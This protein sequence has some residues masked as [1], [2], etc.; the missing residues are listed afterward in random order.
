MKSKQDL[1]VEESINNVKKKVI[2]LLK[3]KI[4]LVEQKE[5][6]QVEQLN[7]NID[8]VFNEDIKKL[9]IFVKKIIETDVVLMQIYNYIKNVKSYRNNT[10]DTL[11]DV[12]QNNLRKGLSEIRNL[13]FDVGEIVKGLKRHTK[14]DL[15]KL[16]QDV[17]NDFIDILG[18]VIKRLLRL[19]EVIRN[20]FQIGNGL[21]EKGEKIS[22]YRNNIPT[23]FERT[24]DTNETILLFFDTLK[25]SI[26]VL[27]QYHEYFGGS[28][29]GININ[30]MAKYIDRPNRSD[31]EI[32]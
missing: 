29:L 15:S 31:N 9:N 25:I 28:D 6:E 20:F 22:N 18:E 7:T 32:D 8:S 26:Q 21:D 1:T 5:E 14:Y 2:E 11:S 3:K 30:N 19:Y 10:A 4:D 13:N 23:L 17:Y 27:Y 16:N 12:Y 24:L